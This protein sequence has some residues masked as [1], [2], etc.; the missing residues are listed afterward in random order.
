MSGSAAAEFRAG[1]VAV[2]GEPNVGKSTLVNRLLGRR[3][4]I[5]SPRP[6]TT[7]HRVLGV[8]NG[9]DYQAVLL[10]TPGLMSPRY[11]LQRLM[12][13]E[14]E[15]ALAD[16][17]VV[18]FMVDASRSVEKVGG[19]W[20]RPAGRRALGVL[21]KVDIADKRLLLPTAALLAGAGFEPVL[22][23]SA[24]T[25]DGVDKLRSELVAALPTGQPF[26][27][28]EMLSERPERFFVAEF[29][30]E[31]VFHRYGAEVPYCTTVVVE[32]FRERPGRKDYVRAIIYVERESQKAIIIGR[33]G[34]ALRQV[35]SR[36]RREAERFLGRP[37]FL[38]L[39]VRVAEGWRRKERFLLE[40]VYSRE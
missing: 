34:R 36:A 15:A 18:I 39:E 19:D 8:L 17:D 9:T 27:P 12:R 10:D 37:V 32:E 31:A 3:L 20:P 6:Q 23:V 26:F 29:V 35:G 38:E 30:R 40:A 5:V 24:L 14:T 4:A 1:Y 33:G 28:I 16:A 25:G 22:M 11:A 2:V 7:R 13:R 21:N